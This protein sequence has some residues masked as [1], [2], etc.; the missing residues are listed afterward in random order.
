MTASSGVAALGTTLT[1]NSNAVPE[2]DNIEMTGSRGE[3]IDITNHDSADQYREYVMGLL[4]GGSINVTGNFLP[5]TA[6]QTALI[7]DHYSRTSRTWIITCSDAGDATF[8]GAGVVESFRVTAP[9]NGKLGFEAT[10]SI[11]GKPTFAA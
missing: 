4:D 2:L 11:S 7:T 8:T 9:V 1:W 3:K 10:I 6:N 5:A